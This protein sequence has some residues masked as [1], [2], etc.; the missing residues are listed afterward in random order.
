[1]KSRNERMERL[2]SRLLSED[3]EKYE[4]NM[5]DDAKRLWNSY[6]RPFKKNIIAALA[7]T[8]FWSG[9]VYM[10]HLL[11]RYLVDS[12]LFLGQDQSLRPSIDVQHE[13]LTIYGV[14]LVASWGAFA[15]AHWA[16]SSLILRVGEKLVFDLRRDLHDKLNRLHVAFFESI[17]TGKLMSRVLEDVWV[18]REWSTN[19]LVIIAAHIL[20]LFIGLVV[21]GFIE[22]RLTLMLVASLPLYAFFTIRI[23]PRIRRLNIALRRLNASMYGL[24]QERISGIAVVKAF[25]QENREKQRFNLRMNNN[26]RLGMS[27]VRFQGI[28]TFLTGSVTAVMGG[29]IPFFGVVLYR[30]GVLTLGDVMVFI[31]SMGNIFFQVNQLA[32][33]SVQIQAVFV[34]IMRVFNVLDEVEEIKPGRIAFDGKD[35]TIRFD[36]VSFSYPN[37]EK[38]MLKDVTVRIPSGSKVALMGPSGSGKSTIFQLICRFYDAQSGAVEVGGINLKDADPVSLRRHAVMVQQE[39]VI[40][41]GSIAENIAYGRVHATPREIMDAAVQAEL[42]D[43]IMTLPAKYETEVGQNGITLSGGQKQ[44]LALATALLTKPKILLLDDTT[45]ALDAETEARIRATLDKVLVGRTSLIITQRIATARTCDWIVVL[46]NGRVAEQ[47][48]H[49]EL[50]GKNGFYHKI[51]VQQE[52]L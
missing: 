26:V 8:T 15:L 48:T 50:V 47:G 1:M 2:I 16:R 6:L 38:N 39:P 37:Q 17:E 7:V 52:S 34:V 5:I 35:G 43:F 20:R 46:E 12:V 21:L 51:F 3:V 10:M 36:H 4:G 31:F 30:Q 27:I 18:I 9:H 19:Q 11:S 23:R 40:F 44:R 49:E 32:G 13:R 24:S 28:L 33:Y 25:G 41:S 42:H 29:L 14:L 22:W 45:S